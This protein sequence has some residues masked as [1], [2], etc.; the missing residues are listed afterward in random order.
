MILVSECVSFQRKINNPFWVVNVFPKKSGNFYWTLNKKHTF[1][2]RKPTKKK[3]AKVS[4]SYSFF[5]NNKPFNNNNHNNNNKTSEEPPPT[6]GELKHALSQ[7]C[8]PTQSQ[9]SRPMSSGHHISMEHRLRKKQLNSDANASN[10][11]YLKRNT[12]KKRRNFFLQKMK[13]K[14]KKKKNQ[15]MKK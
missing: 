12:R 1:Y 10:K 6:L 2:Q 5:L 14:M 13:K 3:F 8:G 7:A 11:T 9:L 4:L 15:K